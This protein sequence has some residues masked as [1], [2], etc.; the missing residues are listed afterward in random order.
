MNFLSKLFN[1]NRSKIDIIVH[2]EPQ[3]ATIEAH[4]ATERRIQGSIVPVGDQTYFRTY[5]GDDYL[6]FAGYG[7]WPD[8]VCEAVVEGDG[9]LLKESIKGYAYEI[10]VRNI[11]NGRFYKLPSPEQMAS[12]PKDSD[13]SCPFCIVDYFEGQ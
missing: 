9:S 10:Y 8:M 2:L 6:T 4:S 5:N 7:Q 13:C 1:R 11:V 3:R 12:F